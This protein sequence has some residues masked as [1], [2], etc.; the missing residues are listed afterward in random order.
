M[1]ALR[2]HLSSENKRYVTGYYDD[3]GEKKIIEI[4][5]PLVCYCDAKW[6]AY[7]LES[8]TNKEKKTIRQNAK[9]RCLH[10]VFQRFSRRAL[11]HSLSTPG[12]RI[13]DIIPGNEWVLRVAE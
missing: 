8:R 4:L 5:E 3:S 12:V 6:L 2:H 1:H 7:K 11:L 10:M 13:H 9:N